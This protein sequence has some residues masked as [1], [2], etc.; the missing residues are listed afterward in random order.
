[1]FL[2]FCNL[3]CNEIFDRKTAVSKTVFYPNK[4]TLNNINFAWFDG[5]KYLVFKRRLSFRKH[6]RIRENDSNFFSSFLFN[7]Y[8]LSDYNKNHIYNACRLSFS[9]CI[10]DQGIHLQIQYE[11]PF[12]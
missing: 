10:S 6:I 12:S 11:Y 8:N 4:L 1:M 5:T 9:I 3:W 7:A 2:E